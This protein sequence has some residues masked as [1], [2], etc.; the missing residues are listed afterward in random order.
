MRRKYR[1]ET[2][3]FSILDDRK[4]RFKKPKLLP[5]DSEA[6]VVRRRFAS[7]VSKREL[8]DTAA[9]RLVLVARE[10]LAEK[11]L[12]KR[13]QEVLDQRVKAMLEVFG[14]PPDES[15]D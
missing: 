11:S 4:K 8:L 10:A 7:G 13:T 2:M 6:A 14:L 9:I 5:Y 12:S 1:D 3:Y 15:E